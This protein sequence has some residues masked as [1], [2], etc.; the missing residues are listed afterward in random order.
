MDTEELHVCVLGPFEVRLHRSIVGP[1]GAR[2]RGVLAILALQANSVVSTDTLVDWVWG[3]RPPTSPR[4]LVQ[5]YVSTWRKTLGGSTSPARSRLATVGAGYRL[6]LDEGEFDLLALRSLLASARDAAGAARFTQAEALYSSSLA[7]FRAPAL[8]DLAREPWHPILA[9]P[10]DE[11]RVDI[12]IAWAR[13]ALRSGLD[14]NTVARELAMARAQH[15]W[16]EE[17]TELLMWAL[18]VAGRQAEALEAFNATRA[19]LRDELGTDPGLALNAMHARVLTA[20]PALRSGPSAQG[21]PIALSGGGP[22]PV[23]G[24]TEGLIGRDELIPAVERLADE[25][26]LVTLLGPGGSG[27]TRLAIEL[28]GRERR[29]GRPGWLIELAPLR[30]IAVVPATIATGIGLQIAAAIDPEAAVAMRL[31][32]A[33]GL[34]VLDN[35]EHLLGMDHLIQRLLRATTRLRVLV[36][37]RE[38][39]G[40]A[41]EQQV[42]VPP[43]DTPR[44]AGVL[45]LDRLGLTPSVQLLLERARVHDPGLELTSGNASAFA[46]LVQLL[47]GLPLGIEIAAAWLRLM[48]PEALVAHLR[49]SGL[50]VGSRRSDSPSRHRSLRASISWSFELLTP[51]QQRL[52]CRLSVFAGGFTLPAAQAVCDD[53]KGFVVESLFDLVDRNLVHVAHDEP[54]AP[55]FRML[56]AVHDFAGDQAA[57]VLG[58][59]FEALQL[60]HAEWYASWAADL[61]AHSEGPDSPTWLARAVAEADNLRA[62]ID[63]LIDRGDV[64]G[65]LQLVA[66]AMVLWFEAGLEGEGRQRLATALE[67]APPDAPARPIALAYWAWLRAAGNRSEAAAAA[68]EALTLSRSQGDPLVEAFALQTLGDTLV[69]RDRAIAASRAVFEAAERSEGLVVRYGPTAPDAVRCGASYSLATLDTWRSLTNAS[70][71]QEEALHRAELEG[72]PR[73]VAVN[74]ARLG[75]IRLLTGDV[76]AA[77]A[78][79]DRSRPRVSSIVTSRWE[80]IVSFTEATLLRHEGQVDA[81]ETHLRRLWQ[82][83]LAGGRH[84]HAVLSAASLAE[85]YAAS[86]RLSDAEEV[87]GQTASALGANAEPAHQAGLQTRRARVR[88]LQGD[89]TAAAAQLD[90]AASAMPIVELPP[91]KVV[92]LLECAQSACTA[93]DFDDAASMLTELDTAA[94]DV[95]LQLPP[96]EDHLRSELSNLVNCSRA[97]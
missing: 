50:D 86:G 88:R 33:H 6:D 73:I 31:A 97:R 36:T 11:E 28:L 18:A 2:R 84:L 51:P 82:T 19:M 96:W 38:P 94:A 35:A 76:E 60:S 61:A 90:M 63:L 79:V 46:R 81:A 83:T 49:T 56:Q 17:L 12:L 93:G 45:D 92:W 43:L 27:K 70:T 7:L 48:P 37:S 15:P 20:D 32:D 53:G 55:R 26:R 52:L 57:K 47:D 13:S 39:L 14:A 74:C 72:D 40:I 67:A 59:D 44:P 29:R 68:Q 1:A 91:E 66:D 34:L 62:A 22:D 42:L 10:L 77:R 3:D 8:V 16:R 75:A 21:E 69:D 23:S 5:T 71:W 80:D 89:A 95:G 65:H 30:D 78:L 58:S 85:I 41:T 9:S 4:N 25:R 64:K 54:D 87:L 24:E